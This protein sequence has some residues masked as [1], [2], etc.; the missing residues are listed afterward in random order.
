MHP[1]PFVLILSAAAAATLTLA[2]AY[3]AGGGTIAPAIGLTAIAAAALLR[4]AT[5]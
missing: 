5:R 3:L 1:R 4:W 2:V